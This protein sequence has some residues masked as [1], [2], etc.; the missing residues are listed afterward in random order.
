MKTEVSVEGENQRFVVTNLAE[1]AEEVYDFYAMRGEVENQMIKELKLDTNADRLSCH[2]FAA[3]QFRLL[4][5]G[6]AYT[7]LLG[8]RRK[9]HGT[10]L[11]TARIATLRLRLLRVAARVRQTFRRIW[12][13]LPS[14]Y[15]F[16]EIWYTLF[17]RLCP[18]C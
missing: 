5:H 18:A 17:T 7:L 15:S 13:E 6:F 12:I 1:S 4:L 2:R 10:E 3:N 9:L 16:K 8:L 14:S 11:A